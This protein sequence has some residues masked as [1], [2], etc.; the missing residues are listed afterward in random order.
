MEQIYFDLA[1]NRRNDLNRNFSVSG[2]TETAIVSIA[3]NDYTTFS[4]ATSFAI[5]THGEQRTMSTSIS[6]VFFKVSGV[7]SAVVSVATGFGSGTTQNIT[8]PATITDEVGD[9]ISITV[10]GTQNYL[11]E[12]VDMAG[13]PDP[14]DCRKVNIVFTGTDVKVYEI[15]LLDKKYS[16]NVPRDFIEMTIQ[17][18]DRAGGQHESTLGQISRYSGDATD[19]RDKIQVDCGVQFLGAYAYR[20]FFKFKQDYDN[21]VVALNTTTYPHLVFTASFDIA[22]FVLDDVN[23]QIE[24]A[25]EVAF[26]IL[27]N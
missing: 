24:H 3:D 14:F 4:D 12:I 15:M 23:D 11:Y 9:A 27:E 18:I 10:D 16:F 5:I 8:F 13:D 1:I 26:S 6:H 20:P 17:E 2:M 21:F 25:Q 19:G 7:T 22:P